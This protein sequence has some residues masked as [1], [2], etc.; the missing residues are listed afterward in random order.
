VFRK[1]NGPDTFYLEFDMYAENVRAHIPDAVSSG[2]LLLDE[3]LLHD[4]A[5]LP[6][7]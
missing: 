2:S 3:V 6:I 1:K 4:D 5:I 7:Y